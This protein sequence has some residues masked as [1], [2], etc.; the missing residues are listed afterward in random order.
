MDRWVVNSGSTQHDRQ[1]GHKYR[2]DDAQSGRNL[3]PAPERCFTRKA[4]GNVGCQQTGNA[5]K[6][7]KKQNHIN[8]CGINLSVILFSV[9]IRTAHTLIIKLK[10]PIGTGVF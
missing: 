6:Y 2:Y 4:P 8:F 1:N 3:P 9:I 7:E 5:K 10:T